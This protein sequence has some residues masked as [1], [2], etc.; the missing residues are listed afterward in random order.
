MRRRAPGTSETANKRTPPIRLPRKLKHFL[1][2]WKEAD[3]GKVKYVVHYN[4]QQIKRDPWR[5][6]KEA[7][8]AAKLTKVHPH[9]L[10]HTR[11]TWMVQRG[12][13]PWQAAGYLGMTVR[14]LEQTYGHH[15]PDWQA[16]AADI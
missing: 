6:W 13:P 3:G 10:R 7:C 8:K 12:V 9:V 5:S 14:V 4:G 16:D 1:Q 2:R 11:A 15:S